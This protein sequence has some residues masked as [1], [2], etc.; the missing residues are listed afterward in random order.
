MESQVFPVL[1]QKSCNQPQKINTLVLQILTAI[2]GTVAAGRPQ[3]MSS[4]LTGK[5]DENKKLF[6][7][8]TMW[9]SFF[10]QEKG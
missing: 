9:S 7:W 5:V 2:T 4:L 1:Q 8:E 3:V 6:R 10:M